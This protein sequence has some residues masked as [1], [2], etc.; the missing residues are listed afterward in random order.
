MPLAKHLQR[1]N[2][3]HTQFGENGLL[4]MSILLGFKVSVQPDTI[5]PRQ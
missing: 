1:H 4:K 2:N 3:F 5:Q